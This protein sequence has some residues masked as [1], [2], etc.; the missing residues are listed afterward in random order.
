MLEGLPSSINFASPPPP[1][2]RLLAPPNSLPNRL[3]PAREEPRNAAPPEEYNQ[4]GPN[5]DMVAVDKAIKEIDYQLNKFK[6]N[7]FTVEY[8]GDYENEKKQ[9]N[10]LSHKDKKELVYDL[11]ARKKLLTDYINEPTEYELKRNNA[12]RINVLGNPQ[13]NGRLYPK[14]IEQQY[15][16]P[17]E[18][19]GA[20]RRTKHRSIKSRTKRA[21]RKYRSRNT[22]SK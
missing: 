13:F 3:L 7:N 20:V 19:G 17:P 14:R 8:I 6:E 22:R 21:S 15:A 18:Y 9:F 5:T 11:K 4:Y 2:N 1:N 10:K 12:Y 16:E